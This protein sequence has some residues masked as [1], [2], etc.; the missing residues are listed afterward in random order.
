MAGEPMIEIGSAVLETAS[1]PLS[2]LPYVKE[3]LKTPALDEV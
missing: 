1:L 3:Q 2:L